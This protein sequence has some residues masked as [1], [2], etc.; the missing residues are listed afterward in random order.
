MGVD[1]NNDTT[2]D[3]WSDWQAV[4]ET[5]DY[6]P[7][8]VKHVAKTPAAM[9]LSALPEGYGFQFELNITDTTSNR[10]KPIMDKVVL[11]FVK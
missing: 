3:Q 6:T 9:D 10:S 11:S 1:T 8:F 5:D 7:G 2:V 4:K